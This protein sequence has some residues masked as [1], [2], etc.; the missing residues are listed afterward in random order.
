MKKIYIAGLVA[1]ISTTCFADGNRLPATIPPV[2]KQECASC[3]TLYPPAFLPIESWK[4]IMTGLEKHYGTDASVDAQSNLVITQWLTQYGGTYKRV[5][6]SPPHDRITNSAWFIKKHNGIAAGTWKNPKV[7]SAANC[8]ACH[9][10]A[11]EGVYDDESIVLP[12]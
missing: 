4:R 3:H 7:K 2:V 11:N 9:T 10:R 5:S 1:V 12:K 8:T 6:G